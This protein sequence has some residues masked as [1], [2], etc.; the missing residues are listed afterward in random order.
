MT[1]GN[2]YAGPGAHTLHDSSRRSDIVIAQKKLPARVAK[3]CVC[4]VCCSFFL[5]SRCCLGV[6]LDEALWDGIR[7]VVLKR[8]VGWWGVGEC[9]FLEGWD[10]CGVGCVG[11]GLGGIEDVGNRGSIREG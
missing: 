9:R 6:F 10:G 2:L 8:M 11:N 7:S 1:L 4:I 3:D 5:G